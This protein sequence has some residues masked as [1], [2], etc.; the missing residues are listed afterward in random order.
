MLD[1]KPLKITLW[2][3]TILLSETAAEIKSPQPFTIIENDPVI[4]F[5]AKTIKPG[6]EAIIIFEMDKVIDGEM[7]A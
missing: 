6:Q 7:L 2:F 1:F 4:L 3:A 5:S